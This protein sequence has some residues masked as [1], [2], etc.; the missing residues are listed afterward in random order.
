MSEAIV[1]IHGLRKVYGGKSPV[2]A[3]DGIDLRVTPGELYGLL[4]PNGAGKTTTISIAT[5]R[6]VPTAGSVRIAGVDVV[7]HPAIARRA[8]GI[9]PQ[10][11]TLDRSCTVAENIRFHCL[12][13]GFSSTEARERT[14]ALLQQFRLHDRAEAYPQQL[15]GGLAQRLQIAR[16]IAHRPRV[17]FLDEPSAGLDPQSRIAMWEAVRALREEG[18]TVVLTT[19]YMEEADELCDRV[20]IIDHGRILVEDTP[21][22]LKASVG[23]DKLYNLRLREGTDVT[24]LTARLRALDG[25]AGVEPTEDG[26]RVLARAKDGLLSQVVTTANAFGLRDVS[27]A[28]PSLETVFIRLTGRDL[29]E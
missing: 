18:I 3:V 13:F 5:T 11:N 29:R 21:A 20:A 6:A 17:L 22:A 1:D 19:H 23:G 26:L 24:A 7:A 9:V 27:T 16:A 12:Y 28:E 15:S 8:I 25:V 4:G 2:T 10:Y 14:A